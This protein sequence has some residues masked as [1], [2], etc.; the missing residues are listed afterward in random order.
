MLLKPSCL[1]NF[2][3]PPSRSFCISP[4]SRFVKTCPKYLFVYTVYSHRFSCTKK[5]SYW[6][7]ISSENRNTNT[8]TNSQNHVLICTYR[9]I[10]FMIQLVCSISC[11][12]QHTGTERSPYSEC[13]F[14][15]NSKALLDTWSQSAKYSSFGVLLMI[16]TE[17]LFI[18]CSTW[19]AT[20][21]IFYWSHALFLELS[22]HLVPFD[23]RLSCDDM[24]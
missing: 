6:F 7:L 14:Y 11:H 3:K 21:C 4:R 17:K 1:D 18:Y 2:V 9:P 16:R 12:T 8:H 15:S 5:L 19:N 13:S 20:Y 22:L 10:T 23:H 24:L